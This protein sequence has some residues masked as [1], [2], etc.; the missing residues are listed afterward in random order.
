LAA[1]DG[2]VKSDT[3]QERLHGDQ[4]VAKIPD[5]RDS[6]RT[7]LNRTLVFLLNAQAWSALAQMTVADVQALVQKCDGLE[8]LGQRDGFCCLTGGCRCVDSLPF[9][10]NLREPFGLDLGISSCRRSS[11][12]RLPG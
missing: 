7:P 8:V 9:E 3:L 5:C 2:P 12:G 11:S 6:L 10:S 1:F 4:S